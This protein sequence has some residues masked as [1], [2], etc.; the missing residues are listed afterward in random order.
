[1]ENTEVRMKALYLLRLLVFCAIAIGENLG[2]LKIDFKVLR[3]N[4]KRDLLASDERPYIMKRDSL[5]MELQNRQTFYLAN[6]K[7]GS[8]EDEVEVLVDTGSSDLW[9]MSHD[10]HCKSS[11]SSTSSESLSSSAST[12]SAS[13]G[14]EDDILSAHNEK[15]AIHGVQPLKWN[16]TLVEYAADYADSSFSCANVTLVHSNGPYGENLAAGYS[17][18]YDPVDAWYD[19]IE[20]YDFNNPSFNESTGH[21]T[22]L[23]WKSTSQLGCARVICD[24]AW[25]QYTICEY[26]KTRGNILGTNSETGL[27]YFAE[28]V[29]KPL[30]NSTN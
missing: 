16:E 7:I 19:E 13:S 2:A 15:R 18:G 1:M 5:E 14:F 3:G 28:N 29:L 17:G 6:I 22:Q 27:S 30:V 9:V 21:F 4:D 11:S 8:N 25:G 12:V 10:S 23:I 24:N 26:S 20:L